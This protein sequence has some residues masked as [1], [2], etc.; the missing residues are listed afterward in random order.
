[1]SQLGQQVDVRGD[2]LHVSARQAGNLLET[3]GF[4]RY[5]ARGHVGVLQPELAGVHLTDA[6]H[7]ELGRHLF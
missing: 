7:E 5:T 6:L 3:L 4:S 1:M 2:I